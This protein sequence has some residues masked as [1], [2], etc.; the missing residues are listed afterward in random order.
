MN[1]DISFGTKLADEIKLFIGSWKYI[2]GFIIFN[3]LWMLVNIPSHYAFDRYPYI[4]LNL[5]ISFISGVYG[6]LIMVSQNAQE[7]IQKGIQNELEQTLLS[8]NKMLETIVHMAE[9]E[10]ETLRDHKYLLE[11]LEK[12]D[13]EILE[14][15]IEEDEM[16]EDCNH[17]S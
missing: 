16:K 7:K 17:E 8:M 15:L 9:A 10:R 14:E 2:S 5:A 1:N 12:R 4:L 13:R 11:L 6:P 3:A